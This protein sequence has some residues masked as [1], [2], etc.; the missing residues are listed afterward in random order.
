M[1]RKL[2]LST[3]TIAA[4]IASSGQ[5]CGSDENDAAQLSQNSTADTTDS[6]RRRD[7]SRDPQSRGTAAPDDAENDAG[8]TDLSPDHQATTTTRATQS[9]E[10]RSGS[11]DTR[12][13]AAH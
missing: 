2:L 12:G 11:E 7:V 1:K 10:P 13:R 9:P 8:T 3:L 4:G 6:D 5:R